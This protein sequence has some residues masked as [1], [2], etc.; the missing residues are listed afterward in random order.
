MPDV[1]RVI[2]FEEVL[3]ARGSGDWR[4]QPLG[5]CHHLIVRMGTA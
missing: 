5:E 3:G 2:V 4:L 1:I